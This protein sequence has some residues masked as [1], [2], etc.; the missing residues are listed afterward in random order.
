MKSLVGVLGFGVFIVFILVIGPVLLIWSVNS[1]AEA[2]GA[3]FYIDH[4]LWNYWVALVFLLC[5]GRST[6]SK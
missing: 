5:V 6:G 1:L 3:A 4:N 2:G